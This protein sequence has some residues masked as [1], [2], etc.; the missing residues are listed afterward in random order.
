[1]AQKFSDYYPT[2]DVKIYP[3]NIAGMVGLPK[4]GNIWYVDPGAGSDTANSGTTADDAFATVG[5]AIGS[6][7]ADQDYV[8]VIAGTSST[9]RTTE[10]AAVTWSKRRTHLV[11]NG[12]VRAVNSRNGVNVAATDTASAFIISA[13]N[14]SFSNIS[15]AAFND[16]DVLVEIT[17]GNNTFNNVHFQE[18]GR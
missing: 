18:I 17:A 13:T 4:V 2:K 6:A 14:C 1:M 3:E 10:T 15:I 8:I 11:G 9:G 5:K 16:S 7:T 12:P